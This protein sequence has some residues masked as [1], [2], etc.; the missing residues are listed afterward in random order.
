[1]PHVVPKTM[2]MRCAAARAKRL[3]LRQ[4]S[5]AF[6]AA[7]S[8]KRQGTAA[9]QDAS[10]TCTQPSFSGQTTPHGLAA[11]TMKIGPADC[12]WFGARHSC[13]FSGQR[14]GGER[15]WRRLGT[16]DA[17]AARMPRPARRDRLEQAGFFSCWAVGA[18]VA[19]GRV[20][21]VP[22]LAIPVSARPDRGFQSFSSPLPCRLVDAEC[23]TGRRSGRRE[24]ERDASAGV[25]CRRHRH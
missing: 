14:G 4:S 7:R 13:R 2:R 19:L 24:H 15:R 10:R 17:D 22:G 20:D 5:G 6:P 9:L 12:R 3:G 16:T 18:S 21:E 25:V 23:W 11:R 1:M 8:Q